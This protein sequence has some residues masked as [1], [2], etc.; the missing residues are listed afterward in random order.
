V[1]LVN[2]NNIE[3]N[4]L[5]CLHKKHKW[6]SLHSR[7]RKSSCLK[8]RHA[9]KVTA[10]D[11]TNSGNDELQLQTLVLFIKAKKKMFLNFYTNLSKNN[12]AASMKHGL[13]SEPHAAE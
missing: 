8:S 1:E 10:N 3:N 13:V 7:R 5:T 6:K 11:G 4:F 9:C 12:S 2:S